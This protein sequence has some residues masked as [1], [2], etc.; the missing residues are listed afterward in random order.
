MKN[1]LRYFNAKVKR[2]SIFKPAIGNGSLHQDCNDY[3]VR[4][5]NLA[6]SKN[7]VVK[8]TM[9]VHLN[10]HKCN[11][12]SS[13]GKKHNQNDNILI[14][15]RWHSSILYTRIF[16]GADC[17]IHMYLCCSYSDVTVHGTQIASSCVDSI[18]TLALSAVCAQC[19]IW[20]FSVVP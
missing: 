10:I 13:D 16:S 5:V 19:P 6:T 14:D 17:D 8:S 2:E 20:L 9:F 1:Q 4:I 12:S 15:R 3:G 7:L 18:S 11:W